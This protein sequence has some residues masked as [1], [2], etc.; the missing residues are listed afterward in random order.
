VEV[1]NASR[2]TALECFP[3]IP[4]EEALQ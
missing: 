2:D 3:R 1:I 4:I